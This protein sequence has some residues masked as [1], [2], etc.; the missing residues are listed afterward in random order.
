MT[1]FMIAWSISTETKDDETEKNIFLENKQFIQVTCTN[2]K[3][4]LYWKHIISIS[5]TD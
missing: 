2:N 5:Q 1:K 3:K 4:S